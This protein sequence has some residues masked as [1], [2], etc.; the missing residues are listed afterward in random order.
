MGEIVGD[1]TRQVEID[2]VRVEWQGRQEAD[3]YL[4]QRERSLPGNGGRGVKDV[5]EQRKGVE[6]KRVVMEYERETVEGMVVETPGEQRSAQQGSR[7][8]P[9]MAQME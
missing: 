8:G 6:R 1:R 3:G 7:W 4:Q 2:F 9:G 5:V